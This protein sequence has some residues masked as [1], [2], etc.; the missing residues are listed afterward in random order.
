MAEQ[1]ERNKQRIQ[2]EAMRREKLQKEH[3]AQIAA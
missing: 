2:E 1:A 3:Y